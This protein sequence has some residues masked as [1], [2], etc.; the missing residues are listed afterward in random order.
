MSEGLLSVD[1][2]LARILAHASPLAEESVGLHQARGR[3]LTRSLAAQ[4]TQP[5]SDLSAMDGYAIRHADLHDLARPLKLVGES[6]AGRSFAGSLQPGETV[7]I[8]TGA[9]V[10]LGADTVLIQE[11]A[12]ADGDLVHAREQPVIGRNIRT[13]GLDFRE[14]EILLDAGTR[15]GASE[16]A[17]A[18]A[19][20]HA[21]LPV[22]RKPLVAIIATGDELVKPGQPVGPDQI[23]ASNSYAVAAFVE[24]AGGEALDLG[25]V[26][27]SLPAL[28]AAI[29]AACSAGADVLVTLGGASVGDHDLVKPALARRG[30]ELGFW[31]IAMRPGKPLIHGR[32]ERT[33]ILGL[34]GNPVSSIVCSVLFLMPLIRTLCGDPRASEDLSE[35][36][37]IGAPLPANDK[38]QDYLRATLHRGNDGVLT[39]TPAAL[40]DSSMLRVL[41]SAECLLIRGPNATADPAGAPCRI[42]RLRSTN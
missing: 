24:Q 19:M 17:L 14:G 18:A 13:A 36:A 7:R 33:T 22:A 10:P 27:D 40:Q 39:A 25:I 34:P 1:E 20:N 6:A 2:A 16:I 31:R 9:P 3:T 32:M 23:V 5:P 29:D 42:L 28:E 41:A 21:D 15:L 4:R 37:V 35:P 11:M 8:F 12:D 38:R 26:A 30:M